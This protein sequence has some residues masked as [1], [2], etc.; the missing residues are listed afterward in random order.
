MFKNGDEQNS[1]LWGNVSMI[2]GDKIRAKSDRH[3]TKEIG[4][5]DEFGMASKV[6]VEQGDTREM[7]TRPSSQTESNQ[8]QS[9]HKSKTV[10]KIE[11]R[12]IGGLEE[13]KMG[14][15]LWFMKRTQV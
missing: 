1:E 15:R 3:A 14:R 4:K 8:H 6:K 9:D 11:S 5:Q 10:V 13:K 7:C 2:T 12:D